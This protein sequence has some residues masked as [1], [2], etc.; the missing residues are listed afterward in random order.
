MTLHEQLT[1][2]GIVYK[3]LRE[4]HQRIACPQCPEDKERRKPSLALTILADGGAVWY[5]HRCG[6]KGGATEGTRHDWIKQYGQTERAIQ[7]NPFAAQAQ[8]S[9]S[10]QQAE[11]AAVDR[12]REQW[13]VA[14]PAD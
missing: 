11:A 8:R 14:A 6:F 10:Q 12:A 3:S 13:H 9:A 4:G 1:A 7:R 2:R 5:C